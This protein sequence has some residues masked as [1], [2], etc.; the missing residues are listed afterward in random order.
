MAQIHIPPT[1]SRTHTIMGGK[2]K[3][4]TKNHS[5][6]A[7]DSKTIH[8]EGTSTSRTITRNSV[9]TGQ[10]ITKN[11]VH[12]SVQSTMDGDQATSNPN[13]DTTDIPRITTTIR[14]RRHTSVTSENNR[15][16]EITIYGLNVC[17][18]NS[19]LDNGMLN[20]Y[21]KKSDIF[22]ISE[23]K[24]SK[25]NHID[26]YT[27]FNLE[28]K[29]K[30]YPLPGIHGLQVYITDHIAGKCCQ[31]SD[32][33][34]LCEAVLWINVAD[35]FIVGAL[36]TPHEGSKYY[37]NDYF[38]DLALEI[39]DIKSKYDLPIMLIGD[40]NSRTGSLND[41]LLMEN[42]DDVLDASNF[43]Y[44]D[45][46]NILNDLNLPVNRSNKDIK[47]NNNGK[48]LID[49]CKCLELCIVNGRIGSDK[50]I[51]NTTCNDTSTIDYVLCTPDLL[52][53]ITDF[54]VHDFDPLLSDK[55]RPISVSLNLTKSLHDINTEPTNK[56]EAD[57]TKTHYIK[58]KWDSSKK[59]EYIQNFDM[60][61]IDTISNTLSTVNMGGVTLPWIDSIAQDLKDLLIEP[62]TTTG[63]YKKV[64]PKSKKRKPNTN[65][66]WFN[67][68]CKNS[69]NNYKTF[70]NS[71]K[72]KPRGTNTNQLN[73][74]A[75]K[76]KRI[77]RSEKRKYE[78]R[79]LMPN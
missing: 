48:K 9:H 38:T 51:G 52:P 18:L 1:S 34:S 61:K 49:M 66:P 23:S 21:I 44:P 42:N 11:S 10:M 69:K 78:K 72:G 29:P 33:N 56:N 19:K 75:K 77:I 6:L 60:N 68:V 13:G 76:H 67:E 15:H 27:V 28:N 73:S 50:S 71:L 47:I 53:N 57:N 2:T 5:G 8:I 7:G 54:T 30:K 35:S 39:C 32:I 64:P 22:C 65:K 74:L 63:M 55:H 36:Y 16:T 12:T 25:G 41:I 58:C 62:A 26:N 46:I 24:V 17:G 43:D 70:K 3:N 31:I 20:D 45:I 59:G 37:C 79:S 14:P 40:F 4:I